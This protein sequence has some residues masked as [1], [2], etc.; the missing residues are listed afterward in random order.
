MSKTVLL[1]GASGFL[2]RNTYLSLTRCGYHVIPLVR[3]PSGFTE[4]I[5]ADISEEGLESSLPDLIPGDAVVHL[6]ARVDFS[7]EV[8]SYLFKVN[9]LATN[10]LAK[11][12]ARCEAHFVFASTC[13]VCGVKTSI[14]KQDT[15]IKP[16][17]YYALSKWLAE[18]LVRA[19]Q[20][21]WVILRFAGLYGASGPHHLGL[22][23]AIDLAL[24]GEPPELRG[25]GSGKHNY[26][27]VEDAA[28]MIAHCLEKEVEGVHFCAGPEE[29]SIKQLLEIICEVLLVGKT[30]IYSPGSDT[31]DQIVVH[32]SSLFAGH[33][34]KEALTEIKMEHFNAGSTIR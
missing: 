6:A 24:S 14:I 12:A 7:S 5:I 20:G 2:G 11:Y 22:N 27:F 29:H 17:T 4:E 34:F 23:K 9:T 32:S 33:P 18:E 1:T 28:S 16:D 26:L 25:P 30:P 31:A 13:T 15:L 3:R 19:S 10:K 21:R 8:N